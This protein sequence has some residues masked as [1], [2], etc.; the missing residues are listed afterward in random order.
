MAWRL[1]CLSELAYIRFNPPVITDKKIAWLEGVLNGNGPAMKTLSHVYNK[2]SKMLD[3]DPEKNKKELNNQLKRLNYQLITTFDKEGTQA[4]LVA[5]DDHTVLV[6][7]GT[8]KDIKDIKADAN[9]VIQACESGGSIHSGF[10]QAY[11]WVVSDIH[12]ALEQDE[13]KNKPLFI[14]GHSLGGALATIAA[15]KLS[16]QAGIAACYTFGA[17]RVGDEHWISEIKTPIYRLINAADCV[18]MLPPGSTFTGV[19]A[20]GV[21]YI[22]VFGPTLR[23]QLL[24]KFDGYLHGGNMRYL[25]NC[26]RG[27]YEKVRLLYSVDL[28]YRLKGLISGSWANTLTWGTWKNLVADHAIGTYRKKLYTI[29]KRRNH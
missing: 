18:P 7:R 13:I 23:E 11:Q 17:P 24:D 16:H 22:P 29:A 12:A 15:K 9:A 21:E 26:K 20:W 6:F 19:L 5:N 8:E 14:T 25:T 1:A 3:Y 2:A 4:I 10:Q 27:D 28:F